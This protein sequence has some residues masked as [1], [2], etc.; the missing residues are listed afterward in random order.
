MYSIKNRSIE[1]PLGC[2]WVNADTERWSFR[3]NPTRVATSEASNRYWLNSTN[4]QY[5]EMTHPRLASQDKYHMLEL[6]NLPFVYLG[7][8]CVYVCNNQYLHNCTLWRHLVQIVIFFTS[9]FILFFSLF[10][11]APFA[12]SLVI[13]RIYLHMDLEKNVINYADYEH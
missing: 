10:Q 11:R 9:T 3:C 5:T 2:L 4:Y 6:I 13:H 12:S 7:H 8:F 1:M